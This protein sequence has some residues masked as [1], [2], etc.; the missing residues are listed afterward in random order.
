MLL[1]RPQIRKMLRNSEKQVMAGKMVF[2]EK[3][4]ILKIKIIRSSPQDDF[5]SLFEESLRNIHKIPN[6]PQGLLS[7][8]KE[9]TLYYQLIINDR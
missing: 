1:S 6:P 3:G 8:E 7:N 2:D 9:L 4:N 5:Q